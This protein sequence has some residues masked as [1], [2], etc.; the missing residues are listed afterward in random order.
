MM[1]SALIAFIAGVHYWWPKM[2]GKMYNETWAQ[3]GAWLVFIGFNLTFFPLF[4]AGSQ[5][6]PRRYY[7]YVDEYT[8]YHV[9][10]TIGSLVLALGFFIMLGY[11]IHSLVAGK[12]APANPWGSNTLEWHCS[13]PPPHVNF[14]EPPEVGDP[15]DLEDWVPDEETG[16]WV[17]K[18][19]KNTS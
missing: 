15:Y 7:N 10:A 6:M 9:L 12:K 4:V 17:L 13:S 14:A 2:F 8:I 5:G 18:K 11:L 19:D 16:G 1:G 3:V